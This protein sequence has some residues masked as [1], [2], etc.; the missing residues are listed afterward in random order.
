MKHEILDPDF[1]N[2]LEKLTLLSK[3]IFAGKVQ[4][5]R[6]STHKGYSAEFSDHRSYE[7]GDDLRYIDWNIYARIEKLLIKL[8][9]AE[10]EL[11]LNIIIDNSKSMCC[12]DDSKLLYAKKIAAA[13]SY[14]S[15][16]HLDRVGISTFSDKLNVR[17]YPSRGRKHFF[18]CARYLNEMVEESGTDINKSLI[19]FANTMN[20]PGV[21]VFISDFFDPNGYE[22]G[23]NYLIYKKF[24][25]NIIQIMSPQER[26]MEMTGDLSLTDIETDEHLDVT[27]TEGL[28]ETYLSEFEDMREELKLFCLKR[29]ITYMNAATDMH[30]EDLILHYFKVKRLVK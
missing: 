2:R 22:R 28:T 14:I 17:V 30:F 23:L 20:M 13:L 29:G 12:P 16:S 18:N 11:T 21:V 5:L 19:D 1:I 9:V 3:K 6:R 7:Q 4:S 8:F 25:V 10:E 27:I 15:L 24:D 26:D